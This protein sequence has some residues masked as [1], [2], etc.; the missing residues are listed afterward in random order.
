MEKFFSRNEDLETDSTATNGS[1]K[2]TIRSTGSDSH[3]A[4]NCR[5]TIAMNL[6]ARGRMAEAADARCITYG[7]MPTAMWLAHDLY[8]AG[9]DS[10]CC[11]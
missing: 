1:S 11:S 3:P 6:E 9:P 5:M 7:G 2:C 8:E 10:D 4:A